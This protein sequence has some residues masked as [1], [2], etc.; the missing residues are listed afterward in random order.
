M[1]HPY[2]KKQVLENMEK[3]FIYLFFFGECFYPP[4]FI[5]PTS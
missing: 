5:M 4:P 2:I 1:Q 3:Y